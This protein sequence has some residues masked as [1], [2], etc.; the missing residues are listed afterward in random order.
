MTRLT[1]AALAAGVMVS[2]TSALTALPAEAADPHGV[3]SSGTGISRY[4]PGNASAIAPVLSADGDDV[5]FKC[6]Y[7]S[8]VRTPVYWTCAL[9]SST[10]A[11][12]ASYSGSKN[13]QNFGVPSAGRYSHSKQIGT[14][15]CTR[16]SAYNA[17]GADSDEK[18]S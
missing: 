5:L 14:A 12:I 13:S 11:R 10:G 8:W 16:A 17:D 6:Q 7:N 9:Y 2:L 15:Y 3:G 18:C 1:Q 4:L